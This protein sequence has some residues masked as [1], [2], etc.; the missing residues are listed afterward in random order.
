[1]YDFLLRENLY[2]PIH[3]SPE[4]M[5]IVLGYRI[6]LFHVC[7]M[8]LTKFLNIFCTLTLLCFLHR[9]I[10][11]GIFCL[12]ERVW[13]GAVRRK[14]PSG[15][16]VACPKSYLF[17]LPL[18]RFL[19]FSYATQMCPSLADEFWEPTEATQTT[20][21]K[22]WLTPESCTVLGFQHGGNAFKSPCV[23]EI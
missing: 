9:I 21:V 23:S 18:A 17:L 16:M 13:S 7:C 11:V 10:F 5:E 15:Y 8:W 19:I 22:G 2:R 6:L 14:L 12:G 3:I 1:M 20:V 4:N